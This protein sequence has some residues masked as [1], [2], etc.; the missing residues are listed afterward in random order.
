[1]GQKKV[2]GFYLDDPKMVWNVYEMIINRADR[3]PRELQ[4]QVL[5][6][7]DKEL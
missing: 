5:Y 6:F 2:I 3:N 7:I 1:M 4:V